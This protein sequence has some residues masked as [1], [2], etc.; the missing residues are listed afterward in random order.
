MEFHPHQHAV[1]EPSLVFLFSFVFLLST[2]LQ[3][4]SWESV[5]PVIRRVYMYFDSNPQLPT[6]VMALPFDLYSPPLA[7]Q[8]SCL[9]TPSPVVVFFYLL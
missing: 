3:H 7:T 6:T 2:T 9:H 8:L 4:V 5:S 1:I